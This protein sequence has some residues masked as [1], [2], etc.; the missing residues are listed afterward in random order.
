MDIDLRYTPLVSKIHDSI[1]LVLRIKNIFKLEGVI[2]SQDCCCN[3]LSRSL[4]IFPRDH[5]VLKP[6]EQKL[7][8]VEGPFIDELSRL[9]IVKILDKATHNMMMLKL[10]LMWNLA[11]PDVTNNGLDTIIF[12][13]K[14][15][16]G[17]ID[18]RSLGYY[19]IKQGT[20]QQNL[21]KY[22]RFK[23]A[24]ALCEQFNKFINTLKK[25]R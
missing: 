5:I 19:I 9:A 11:T 23:K 1:D 17:I 24:D 21:S 13:P 4:P 10:K 15:V 16:L 2:N 6:R 3:F 14:E 22:Y 25:E 12:D 18:L 7:I 20:L 8:K